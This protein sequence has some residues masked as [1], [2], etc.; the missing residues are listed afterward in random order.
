MMKTRDKYIYKYLNNKINMSAI[1]LMSGTSMDGVDVA[2]IKTDG[3]KYYKDIFFE[4]Y[5][6][7]LE[8]KKL[9]H[10]FLINKNKFMELND[11]I[12]LFHIKCIKKA[13]E[14]NNYPLSHIDII[15]FH[16]QTL[17]H[18]PAESWTWQ[19]GNGKLLS[20]SLEIPVISNFR[21]RDIC[22]GGEGAPLASLWHKTLLN[23]LTKKRYP[24]IFLNIGG[25]SNIT[26]INKLEEIE[27]CYDIGPGNGPVDMIINRYFNLEMDY[28]GKKALLGKIH[29]NLIENILS[30]DWFKKLPPKSLDKNELNTYIMKCIDNILPI[31]KIATLSRLISVCLKH[32]VDL[33]NIEPK[34]IFVSGGGAHNNAIMNGI[35]EEFKNK[36]Q[37][38]DLQKW[39]IDAIE[40]QAFA[41]LAT[42][43]FKGL[44]LTENNVTGIKKD[45]SGGLLNF[46]ISR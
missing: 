19:I 22:L 29:F 30:Y 13:A 18:K 43:S 27:F 2:C 6:Y 34:Y 21:Y 44:P 10:Q 23:S 38:V 45:S 20:N 25:V 14:K 5:K 11:K 40:A 4:T 35:K 28:G 16:G 8:I 17:L 46:P 41:Y 15:G 3:L 9:L 39:N 42:R 31:D 37:F 7:P 12:A 24:C 32:Q 26:Y 33:L 1:G 36:V